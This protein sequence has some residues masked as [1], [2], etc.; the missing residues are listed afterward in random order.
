MVFSSKAIFTNLLFLS[1]MPSIVEVWADWA[2][3]GFGPTGKKSFGPRPGP[4]PGRKWAEP[5]PGL[6]GPLLLH[7]KSQ[8]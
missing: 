6:T 7:G 1:E 2:E 8:I 5:G 3:P 4:I